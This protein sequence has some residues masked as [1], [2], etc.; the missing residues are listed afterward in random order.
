M[1]P[2]FFPFT[3]LTQFDAESII[4]YFDSFIYLS[5]SSV[6]ELHTSESD[7]FNILWKEKNFIEPI[8][9]TQEELQP[10]LSSVK[11]WR[12]WADANYGKQTK[13]GYL[14]SIFRENPYFTS[15]SDIFAIRSQIEKG[16]ISNNQRKIDQN[17]F[18]STKVKENI[19][20]ALLFL[21]LASIADKDNE[22]IDKKLL[23]IEELESNIFAELK[24]D[25]E[26]NYISQN[27]LEPNTHS[28][29]ESQTL[30]EQILTNKILTNQ[31]LIKNKI[32]FMTDR[33]ELMTEQRVCSWLSFFLSK[34]SIFGE[35][36][37]NSFITTS[38]AV[39]DFII[40]ISEKSK[41]MLDIDNL[42]MHKEKKSTLNDDFQLFQL[43]G[44]IMEQIIAII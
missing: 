11:S 34:K 37:S 29:D 28:L 21:R 15:D 2:I 22:D 32:P 43:S 7:W 12:A 9:L 36:S 3:S 41:L 20:N 23:S 13:K 33:G 25:I 19:D 30:N 31:P 16:L 17:N 24:G 10:L 42:K 6:D 40:S 39:V 18:N 5:T 1:K 4:N 14:Q 35:L 38:R 27:I 44:H 8:T 26:D